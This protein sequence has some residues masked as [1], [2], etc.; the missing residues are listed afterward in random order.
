MRRDAHDVRA[1]ALDGFAAQQHEPH[2]AM[3]HIE[4]AERADFELQ[5]PPAAQDRVALAG[6]DEARRLVLSI[7]SGQLLMSSPLRPSRFGAV[8]AP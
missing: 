5:H 3:H 8:P 6:A 2:R 7:V 4:I 1:P